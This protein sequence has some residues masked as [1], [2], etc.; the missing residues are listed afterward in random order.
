MVLRR[1]NRFYSIIILLFISLCFISCKKSQ[2]AP[3]SVKENNVK[4]P[5]GKFDIDFTKMNFNIASSM[6]F[7]FLIQPEE[8]VEKTVLI[9]GQ[10]HTEVYENER[11]FAVFIWDA[12]GCCPQSLSFIPPKNMTFPD[13]FPGEKQEVILSGTLKMVPFN[14]NEEINLIAEEMIF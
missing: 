11:L 12:T 9:K 3:S 7:D 14:N 13:G 6:M 4:M 10:Y 8:Y 1:L 2:T 5:E